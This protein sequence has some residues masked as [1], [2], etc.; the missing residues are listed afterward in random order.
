MLSDDFTKNQLPDVAFQRERSWGQRVIN[1]SCYQQWR[2]LCCRLGMTAESAGN[3]K[4]LRSMME[5]DGPIKS[6]G[7]GIFRESLPGPSRIRRHDEME[8]RSRSTVRSVRGRYDHS[9]RSRSRSD[10]RSRS[11][12]RSGTSL[13]RGSSGFPQHRTRDDY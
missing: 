8:G 13:N 5:Q 9:D 7:R 4:N 3:L 10:S 12:G 11:R 2:A 1:R 6:L